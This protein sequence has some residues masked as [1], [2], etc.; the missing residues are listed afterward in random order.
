MELRLRE[1]TVKE[2]YYDQVEGGKSSRSKM[3]SSCLHGEGTPAYRKYFPEYKPEELIMI[4]F[5]NM[6]EDNALRFLE[7]P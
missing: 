3:E 1:P 4:A 2:D 5:K 6:L 7:E